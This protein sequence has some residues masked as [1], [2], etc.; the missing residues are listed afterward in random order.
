MSALGT[1][2]CAMVLVV[3]GCW[4]VRVEG[5]AETILASWD[6]GPGGTTRRNE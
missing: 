3:Q 1:T 6:A 5:M 2:G 4:S